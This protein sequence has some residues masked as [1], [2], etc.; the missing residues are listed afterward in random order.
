MKKYFILKILIFTCLAS[1]AQDYRGTPILDVTTIERTIDNSQNKSANLEKELADQ[2]TPAAKIAG[3][4]TGSSTE[5]GITEGQLSISLSGGAS[6]N[7]PIAVPPGIN[8]VMP[9]ISLAYNSQG[10]NGMAG[11][12]W[13]ISGIS[14]ITRIPST[15]FHDGIIDPVDFDG[16]DRFAFDGQRLLLKDPTQ[17]YG[18]PDTVYETENFSNVKIT[19]VGGTNNNPDS[20]KVEYPDGSVGTYGVTSNSKTIDTWG[21]AYWQ[22]AQEVRI[23]YSYTTEL[24]VLYL[25]I[26]SYGNINNNSPLNVIQFSYVIRARPE[27]GYIGGQSTTLNYILWEIKVNSAGVGFRNY[28]LGYDEN[29]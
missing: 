4:P 8:G 16:L 7:I 9:Q 6:Y 26:I 14:A 29:S 20:F 12:G 24:N 19:A 18:A 25:A 13:N 23:N 2:T 17:I 28:Y 10:G 22:N 27:Q 1:I 5:V 21:I 3:T 15:L 11:Y